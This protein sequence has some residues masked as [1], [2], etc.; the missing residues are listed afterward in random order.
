MKYEEYKTG[1]QV[2]LRGPLKCFRKAWRQQSAWD[3]TF[4]K[5]AER[6]ITIKAV[7]I[8]NEVSI[9]PFFVRPGEQF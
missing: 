6:V 3:F 8:T 2:I 5:C 7:I 4:K 9:P 1:Q